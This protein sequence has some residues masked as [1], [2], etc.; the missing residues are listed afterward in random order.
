MNELIWVGSGGFLGAIARHLLTVW[1]TGWLPAGLNG[2][3]L[4]PTLLVNAV[5]SFLLALFI[6]WAGARASISE[7]A[8][9]FIAVGFFGGFT[10]FSR[11]TL[12][13]LQLNQERGFWLTLISV[14]AHNAICLAAAALGW[15]MMARRG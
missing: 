9:L 8:R 11:F 12:D 1:A 3:F 14:F 5:G 4:Q 7:S 15:L 10:T 6:G 13:A 2:R